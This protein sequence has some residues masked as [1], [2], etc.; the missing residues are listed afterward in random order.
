MLRQNC[1]LS[2]ASVPWIVSIVVRCVHW[3]TG[4]SRY[5]TA[6]CG[7]KPRSATLHL[8]GLDGSAFL[9]ATS[10]PATSSDWLGITRPCWAVVW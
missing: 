10:L 4:H 3:M 6:L 5:E 7:Q 1:R 8:E 9:E 2:A